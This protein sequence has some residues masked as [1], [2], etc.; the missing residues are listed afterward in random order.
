MA[1][2]LK[3]GFGGG[4]KMAKAMKETAILEEE[5]IEDIALES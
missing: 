4:M 2:K 5:A 3:K 1:R